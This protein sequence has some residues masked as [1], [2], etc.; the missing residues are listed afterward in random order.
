MA[1]I[2]CGLLPIDA[3][4]STQDA[5]NSG[6]AWLVG[7]QDTNGSWGSDY[8]TSFRDTTAVLD[9]LYVLNNTTTSYN[10]GLAWINGGAFF[11]LSYEEGFKSSFN[12]DYFSRKIATLSVSQG[13]L[14]A[15]LST[16]KSLQNSDGGWGI[17]NGFQ[18]D[19]IDSS[20]A[21]FALVRAGESDQAVLSRAISYLIVHQNSDGG[22]SFEQVQVRV[23]PDE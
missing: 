3:R 8:F 12:T 6:V 1:L 10:L 16:A 4:A 11:N 18:S 13:D 14:T 9:T 21:T 15:D 5:I 20:L 17:D 22:W 19:P 23:G 7:N 2:I